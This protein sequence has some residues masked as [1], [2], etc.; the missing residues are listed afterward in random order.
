MSTQAAEGS[1]PERTAPPVAHRHPADEVSLV[2]ALEH[3]SQA[4]LE[5][6]E[7]R[8]ELMQLEI[9]AA[10]SN[11]ANGA[12]RYGSAA[13]LFVVAW[14]AAMGAAFYLLRPSLSEAASLGL[15]AAANAVIAIAL[16]SF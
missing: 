3:V 7:S 5:V 6:V 13:V 1:R 9:R 12:V 4:A 16:I 2:Q 14:V 10:A 15:I 8:A 11:V